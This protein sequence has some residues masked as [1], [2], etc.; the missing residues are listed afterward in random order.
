MFWNR[1]AEK[2]FGLTAEQVFGKKCTEALGG[3]TA[4]QVDV[5]IIAAAHRSLREEIQSG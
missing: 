2:M 4:I 5:G 3:D 1:G